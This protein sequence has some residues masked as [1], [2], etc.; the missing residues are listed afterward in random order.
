MKIRKHTGSLRRAMLSAEEIEPT[1]AAVED[2][3]RR[4]TDEPLHDVTVEPYVARP[5]TRIGWQCT[6]IIMAT[7]RDGQRSPFGFTD[8]PLR[9]IAEL[10]EFVIAANRKRAADELDEITFKTLSGLK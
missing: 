5:D 10:R 1:L 4:H 7:W 2:Y 9:S 6:Y 8:G 3:I